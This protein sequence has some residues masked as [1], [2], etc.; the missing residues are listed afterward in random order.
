M[1]EDLATS[2]ATLLMT[3]G[4]RLQKERTAKDGHYK[5]TGL[6]PETCYKASVKTTKGTHSGLSTNF[7][8]SQG[9]SS[10]VSSGLYGQEINACTG[11][12]SDILLSIYF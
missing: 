10:Y 4:G 8:S 11:R 5:F 2:S 7:G 3:V 9:W 6:R 1:K 12:P